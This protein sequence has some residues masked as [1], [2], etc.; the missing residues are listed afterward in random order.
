MSEKGHSLGWAEIFAAGTHRGKRYTPR[1]LD[2]IV[3]NFRRHSTGPSPLLKVPGV[4][5]HD[6][7]DLSK[8]DLP[9]GGWG[10]QLRHVV[11]PCPA[12]AGKGRPNGEARPCPLCGGKGKRN[13]LEQRFRDLSPEM[14]DALRGKRYDTV[15]AEIYDEP[16]EGIPGVGKMLR[17]VAFLGGEVPQVKG[18][19]SPPAP[20][21]HS[22]QAAPLRLVRAVPF[23]AGTTDKGCWTCFSE[24]SRPRRDRTYAEGEDMDRD[25]MI[26]ELSK[27][28][29]SAD[30]LKDVPDAA[31]GE[32]LRSLESA[33]EGA[34]DKPP[35]DEPPPEEGDKPPDEEFADDDDEP[36][37]ETY[38]EDGEPADP[39]PEV[40]KGRADKMMAKARK[41]AARVGA[42]CM[43]E[44]DDSDPEQKA[45]AM[46]RMRQAG[47]LKHYDEG[48][49][50]EDEYT[51]KTVKMSEVA[52]I[53]RREVRKAIKGD[54]ADSLGELQKFREDT[55]AEARK[56]A[57][58]G[59]LTRLAEQGKVA[60]ALRDHYADMLMSADA[61]TVHKFGEGKKAVSCTRFD[62]I[63]KDLEA[64]P[65][66]FRERMK[67]GKAGAAGTTA[68]DAEVEKVE[69]HYESFAE[70]FRK[71]NTDKAEL[72]TAFKH[73]RK[74]NPELTADEFLQAGRNA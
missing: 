68:E 31:L 47:E 2:D 9:A 34:D 11:R 24:V 55:T 64:L 65:T 53:V 38:A 30:T 63:V 1:D 33:A 7:K 45:A 71:V 61:K 22:E 37:D 28:G 49:K 23:A 70:S 17:R 3:T 25:A 19:R 51:M 72:T 74:Q 43:G 18:L 32:W 50:A 21:S 4:T 29:I 52:K 10:E 46:A 60:P 15:S 48:K 56:Q 8:S 58:D 59:I 6:E 66:L 67:G 5:G 62:K 69:A 42:K 27:R 26:A 54:V 39:D 16:P 35:E 57:V 14:A 40:M 12:C 73:A 41:F 36:A 44:I 20:E 13:V